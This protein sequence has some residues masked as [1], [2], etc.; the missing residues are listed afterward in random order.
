MLTMGCT[1]LTVT[2]LRLPAAAL[3]PENPL[4]VLG[5]DRA[6]VLPCLL[7]DGYGRSLVET[8]LPAVVLEN[9]YLRATVLPGLGGRLY[10]LVHKPTGRDLLFRNPVCQP[11][12]L[13]LRNAW[14][15]GG[16][17]WNLGSTGHTT[18]TCAPMYAGSVAGPDGSPVLRLWEWER[19]RNLVYQVDLWLPPDSEFLYVGVRIRNPWPHEVPAYWWSNAAV[20]RTDDTRILVPASEG[21]HYGYTQQ[22]SRVDASFVTVAD[23][24]AADLF[25]DIPADSPPWIAAVDSSG[26]GLLQAST[27]RLRGRKLFVWGTNPGGRRWQSWLAPGT[28][29]YLEIQ[30]GLAP[31]QFEYVPMP[32]EA[33]WD[34][35][36]AY[37]PYGDFPALPLDLWRSIA[38]DEPERLFSGSGWGALELLRTGTDPLPGTPF[39]SLGDAQ[40]PWLALLDG[41]MPVGDPLSAPGCTLVAWHSLLEAAPESWI[42]LYHLGVARWYDGDTLGAESAWE[43]SL[44][45]AESPWSLRALAFA[46]PDQAAGLLLRAVELAPAVPGLAIEALEALL[47]AGSASEAASVL[48]SLPGSVATLGRLRLLD[49]RIRHALGD[50]AGARAVFDAGF[51]VPDL[52]EGEEILTETWR[53][54]AGDE[55]VPAVYDFRMVTDALREG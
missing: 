38:D 47:A 49:A 31:T 6:K 1:T 43:Q 10:S 46:R 19:T 11:A 24:D 54:I 45:L 15:A 33:S 22:L 3:G 5:E 7:Q 30:A 50:V 4:P 16:V 34:W 42:S 28:D 53:L 41:A 20:P 35:L 37:G 21:W 12:N 8:D 14:F 40:A 52:R 36:E 18:M 25:Y 26:F 27:D 9:D 55:P 17:E 44:A 51:E 39:D 23:R 32:G 29:G 13:A 48:A 2:E